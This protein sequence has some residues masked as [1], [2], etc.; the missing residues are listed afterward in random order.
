MTTADQVRF[1]TFFSRFLYFQ[2]MEFQ[3]AIVDQTL[4]GGD[5]KAT[6][7]A[8]GGLVKDWKKSQRLVVIVT[9]KE[10]SNALFIYNVKTLPLT[11]VLDLTVD[12]IVPIDENFK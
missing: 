10:T 4:L 11:N 6:V 3:I 1:Q 2:K 5:E 9:K 8:D 12:S 7:F